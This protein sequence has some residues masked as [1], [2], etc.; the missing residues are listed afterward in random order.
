MA[1]DPAITVLFYDQLVGD[2]A[3]VE[4]K[5]KE[6]LNI[7]GDTKSKHHTAFFTGESSDYKNPKW[8]WREY[9]ESHWEASG[10]KELDTLYQSTR[11]KHL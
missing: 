1:D 8:G 5:I 9:G 10:G 4:A 2:Q 3:S 6:R 7:T 11:E